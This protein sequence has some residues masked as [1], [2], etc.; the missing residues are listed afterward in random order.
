ME[1][2]GVEKSKKMIENADLILFVIDGSRELE[3][4]D[5]KIHDSINSEKVIGI[6]NKI[7]IDKK[8]D[9]SKL[10]K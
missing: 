6:L 7:D 3:E 10:T 5:I 8:V 9:L 2:I 1:N 4:E